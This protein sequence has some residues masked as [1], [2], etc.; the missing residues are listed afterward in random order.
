MDS[1]TLTAIGL[2]VSC[3]A[4]ALANAA[5]NRAPIAPVLLAA[6][7]LGL[8]AAVALTVVGAGQQALNYPLLTP[9]Y[10]H[11]LNSL[12][13]ALRGCGAAVAALVWAQR[14]RLPGGTAY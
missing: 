12:I 2:G 10:L 4:S 8:A 11:A 7:A 5:A 3:S 9:P 1:G 6:M 13:L 14:R